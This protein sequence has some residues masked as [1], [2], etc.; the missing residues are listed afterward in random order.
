LIEEIND[1]KDNA[2]FEQKSGSMV[3][4]NSVTSIS[5]LIDPKKISEYQNYI[6]QDI[7]PYYDLNQI[8]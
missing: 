2:N 1:D 8:N 3:K 4:I 7:G 5:E 6:Q